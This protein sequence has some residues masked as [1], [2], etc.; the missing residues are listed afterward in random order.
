MIR[1]TE[2]DVQAELR[3]QRHREAQ[4]RYRANNRLILKVK[5]WQDRKDKKWKAQRLRDEK[6]YEEY[7]KQ[8]GSVIVNQF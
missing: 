7:M 1:E 5:S 3:R 4:A 8:E 6:E 2:T